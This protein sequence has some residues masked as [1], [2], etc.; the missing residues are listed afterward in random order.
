MAV[1]LHPRQLSFQR[2]PWSSRVVVTE[3][4]LW[5]E[6]LEMFSKPLVSSFGNSRLRVPKFA[7]QRGSGLDVAS[8]GLTLDFTDTHTLV[9]L[10]I[11]K[12]S[13][14]YQFSKVVLGELI[15]Q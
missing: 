4:C 3:H 9:G 2:W 15:S 14:P 5:P 10:P 7:F 13:F 11:H 1:V 8:L 12:F 6:S